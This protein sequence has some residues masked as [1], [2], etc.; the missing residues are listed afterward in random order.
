M[1]ATAWCSSSMAVDLLGVN[2]LH[3]GRYSSLVQLTGLFRSYEVGAGRGGCCI[4]LL[5]CRPAVLK[6]G[7]EAA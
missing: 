1:I 6:F 7:I 4:Y 3:G 2:E 5:Y